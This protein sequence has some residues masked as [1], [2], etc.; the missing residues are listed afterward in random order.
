MSSEVCSWPPGA[1]EVVR[2]A[3]EGG[4]Q[5]QHA[6]HGAPRGMVPVCAQARVTR[7]RCI[8]SSRRR[9]RSSTVTSLRSSRY[10][11]TVLSRTTLMG[12]QAE[13]RE[14]VALDEAIA[15]SADDKAHILQAII[16]AEQQ[17]MLWEKKIQLTKACLTCRSIHNA[18]FSFITSS[19][20]HASAD[21]R[22]RR[23]RQRWTPTLGRPTCRR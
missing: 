6:H 18:S 1:A 21:P 22:A 9:T 20:T 15:A 7:R 12:L 2:R 10:P 5:A 16:E 13:E 3:A 8:R 4:G 23:P 14:S 17:I 19:T 11:R